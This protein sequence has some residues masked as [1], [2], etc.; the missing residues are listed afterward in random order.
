VT[1]FTGPGTGR[2]RSLGESAPLEIEAEHATVTATRAGAAERAA[3]LAP[4]VTALTGQLAEPRAGVPALDE[5]H[6]KAS[7]SNRVTYLAVVRVT[8][9]GS[10]AG[11]VEVEL[12]QGNGPGDRD[13]LGPPLGVAAGPAQPDAYMI[14]PPTSTGHLVS[15]YDRVIG[16]HRD[17]RFSLSRIILTAPLLYPKIRVCGDKVARVTARQ[18]IV[19]FASILH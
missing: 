9:A 6:Q 3:A 7:C 2:T 19:Q 10:M 4:Q 5:Q 17:S 14:T 15:D 12:A 11:G 16:T 1:V 8:T 13:G 18:G